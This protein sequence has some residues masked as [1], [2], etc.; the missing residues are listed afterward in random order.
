MRKG[1]LALLP[2]AALLAACWQSTAPLIP[3]DEADSPKVA[4]KYKEADSG[5]TVTITKD[6]GGYFDYNKVD[7]GG[8]VTRRQIRFDHL[9][10]DY[11]LVQSRTVTVTGDLETPYYRIVKLAKS[12]IE[13]YDVA[14]DAAEVAFEG[15]TASS[16][17]CTF[18]AY[19]GLK[20]AANARVARFLGGDAASLTWQGTYRK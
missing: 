1:L 19:R 20:D 6:A 2:L 14:C 3:D 15:V 17:D 18:T 9:Q 4:G 7:S 10:G 12:A 8:S 5:A 11:Y 13:E 16:G